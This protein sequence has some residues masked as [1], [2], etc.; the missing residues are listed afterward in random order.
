MELFFQIIAASL[1]VTGLCAGVSL[2]IMFS[3]S[4]IGRGIKK[5]LGGKQ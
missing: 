2:A 3:A 4:L 5:L 1:F